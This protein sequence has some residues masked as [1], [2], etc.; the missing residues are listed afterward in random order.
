MQAAVACKVRGHTEARQ[1]PA[2]PSRTQKVTCPLGSGPGEVGGGWGALAASPKPTGDAEGSAPLSGKGEM[3]GAAGN[4]RTSRPGRGILRT[5]SPCHHLPSGAKR[6]D[7]GFLEWDPGGPGPS[8]EHVTGS[9]VL[10]QVGSR[11]A[12]R[13][14]VCSPSWSLRSLTG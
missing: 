1:S 11:G 10:S 13:P 8:R 2:E 14:G 3:S 9:Q 7:E 12:R 4:L 6:L 5:Q